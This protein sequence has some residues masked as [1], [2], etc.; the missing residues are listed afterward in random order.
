[1]V[2]EAL[3]QGTMAFVRVIGFFLPLLTIY[4]VGLLLGGIFHAIFGDDDDEGDGDV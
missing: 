2:L 3:R 1:M 4:T